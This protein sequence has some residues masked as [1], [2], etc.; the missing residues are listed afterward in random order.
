MSYHPGGAPAAVR[1]RERLVPCRYATGTRSMEPSMGFTRDGRIL[2]QGWA[3]RSGAVDGA[4]L[5]PVVMRSSRDFT[6][7]TDVSPGP[8]APVSSL[9]PFLI[10]DRRTGRAFSVNF[11]ANGQP[12][13]ST[14]AASDDAGDHWSASPLACNG[15]DGESIG[16]GPP[17]TSRP[18][19]YPDLVY[20]CTG[21]T[22]GS[23]QPTTTP[24]C[25]K[26]IDGGR[27]FLPT[28]TLPWP[29]IDPSAENDKF[30]PWVGDPIVGADGAVYL[31]KRF[32]G[33]PEVAISRDEG[34]TWTRVQVA[35]N[36]AGGETPRMAVDG[37]G[38]LFYAWSGG[39]HLPYLAAS[40]DGGRHWSAPL[41]LA[42]RGLREGELPWPATAGRGR[43]EVAYLGSTDAPGKAPYYDYCNYLLSPCDDGAYAH[44]TWNGYMTVVDD[45]F[46]TDPVLQTATVNPPGRPL[47]TGGCSADGACKADLDFIG[48]QYSPAGEPFAAFSDDCMLTR[49]FIPVFG[50]DF[51]PCADNLGEGVVGRLVRRGR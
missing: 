17:V 36:G 2:F 5:R 12:N 38:N 3:L 11:L 9:D 34:L 37:A 31:P 46:A 4:P 13:C 41:P 6:R 7:W 43:V 1:S 16:A 47:F 14:I 33:Q 19:G 24:V 40:R 23:S 10:V 35:H 21:T 22:P 49:D 51:G 20:Y 8:A 25:S 29:L 30:G 26:S 32:A 42:P 18:I 45:A 28:G 27:T 44:V 39:D 50:Q 48:A 15:F